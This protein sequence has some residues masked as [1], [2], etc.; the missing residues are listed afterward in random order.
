MADPITLSIIAATVAVAGSA[1]Q[2]FGQV[3]AGRTQARL[4]SAQAGLADFEAEEAR[5]SA[6]ERERQ[7]RQRGRLAAGAQ[8]AGFGGGGVRVGSGSPL[9]LALETAGEVERGAFEIRRGGEVDA[10]RARFEAG[11]LRTQAKQVRV[12]SALSATGTLL[13]GGSRAFSIAGGTPSRTTA[14]SSGVPRFGIGVD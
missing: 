11:I 6:A 13:T 14:T 12:A 10:S 2:A 5:R 9:L 8:V 3:Q 4:L 1:V 7:F